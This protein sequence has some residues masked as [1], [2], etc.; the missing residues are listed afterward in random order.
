MLSFSFLLHFRFYFHLLLLIFADLSIFIMSSQSIKAKNFFSLSPI[1]SLIRRMFFS[2]FSYIIR[3]LLPHRYFSQCHWINVWGYKG[4]K[5]TNLRKAC[6]IFFH[7]FIHQQIFLLC[8]N[9]V[10]FEFRTP[11]K[12]NFCIINNF[13]TD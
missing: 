11:T 6:K 5:S 4:G 12:S 13:V 9:S 8:S 1:H 2:F 7:V 3:N 10:F